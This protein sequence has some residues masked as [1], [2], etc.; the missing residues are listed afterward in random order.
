MYSDYRNIDYIE[1]GHRIREKREY[2][3]MSRERLSEELDISPQ[4]LALVEYGV[5][6]LSLK[7]TYVLSQILDVPMDY[8]TFGIRDNEKRNTGLIYARERIMSILSR[9][10][11]KQLE[12]LEKIAMIY[13]DGLDE[14]G[15]NK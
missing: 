2:L 3:R 9:C 5:K 11:A 10:S 1:M 15:N 13:V 4:F 12:G 8:L 7:N 14:L 6:G